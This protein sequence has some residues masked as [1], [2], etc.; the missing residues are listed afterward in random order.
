[1]SF[2]KE[3]KRWPLSPGASTE[4]FRRVLGLEAMTHQLFRPIRLAR[5]IRWSL[6]QPL[7]F[8]VQTSPNVIVPQYG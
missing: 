7:I 6:S 8:H 5:F 3:A 2:F 4:P 1:M